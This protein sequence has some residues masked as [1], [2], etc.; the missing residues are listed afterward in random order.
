M[1]LLYQSNYAEK[2]RIYCKEANY[3]Q[4]ELYFLRS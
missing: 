1:D 4:F 3:L 2:Q